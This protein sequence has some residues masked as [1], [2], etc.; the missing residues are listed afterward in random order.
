MLNTLRHIVNNDDKW[1]K[2][3]LKYSKTF[4]H[5]IIDTKAVVDFFNTETGMNLTTVFN[6]YLRH[7]A[8]PKLQ[9]RTKKGKLEFR[10]N[11]IE[12]KFNMPVDI[13][14]KGKK[15]RLYPTNAWEKTKSNINK[16]EDIEVLTNDFYINVDLLK[17]L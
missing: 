1:W 17:K 5:K 16:I 14:I 15:H 6:Q 4:R 2:I 11:V 10:W 8:I 7:A 3:L 12:D 9:L 13:K